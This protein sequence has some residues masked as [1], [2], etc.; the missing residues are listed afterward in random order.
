[1]FGRL[2]GGKA[3]VA[4]RPEALADTRLR[5]HAAIGAPDDTGVIIDAVSAIGD[6]TRRGA[7]GHET[8]I[9]IDDGL[10]RRI[11]QR[12][13]VAR[14]DPFVADTCGQRDIGRYRQQRVTAHAPALVAAIQLPRILAVPAGAGGQA[15]GQDL[16]RPHARA[17]PGGLVEGGIVIIEARLAGADADEAGAF[18]LRI[19]RQIAGGDRHRPDVGRIAGAGI[20]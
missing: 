8:T 10:A 19:T 12:R 7:V 16:A 17:D 1:M 18:D 3:A 9:A 14:L 11:G 2:I 5:R 15:D 6:L 13:A 20:D 4:D